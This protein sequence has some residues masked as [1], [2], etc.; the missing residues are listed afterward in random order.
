MFEKDD[1]L[2]PDDK[3]DDDQSIENDNELQNDDDQ[4]I[5]DDDESQEDDNELQNDDDQLI[6]NDNEEDDKS[7]EDIILDADGIILN[8]ESAED[9]FADDVNDDVDIIGED[10]SEN[11]NEDIDDETVYFKFDTT[12]H[13]L[14]GKHRLKRDTIFYGKLDESGDDSSFYEYPSERNILFEVHNKNDESEEQKQLKVDIYNILKDNTDINFMSNRR[15]PNKQSF[16][17]YYDI[18]LNNLSKKYTKSEIFVEL[19][20]YF[21]DHIFNMYKLLYPEHA[22][23]IIKELRDKGYLS[24]LDDI[25]FV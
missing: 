14:E 9:E 19:A 13:K 4:S 6:E 16:N 10:S 8:N 1:I 20:Y 5:E 3:D 12:S 24:E 2:L 7:I 23:D 21:T 18:L 22:T 25:E 17:D 15:K 11:V